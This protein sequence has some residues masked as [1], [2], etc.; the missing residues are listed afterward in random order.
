MNMGPIDMSYHNEGILTFCKTESQFL[1]QSVRFL[2]CDLAGLEGLTNLVSNH[3]MPLWRRSVVCSYWRLNNIN[4]LST[5]MG[6]WPVHLCPSSPDSSHNP[7]CRPDSGK[8]FFPLF[9]CMGIRLVTA[10]GICPFAYLC[11]RKDLRRINSSG[12]LSC[13]LSRKDKFRHF[14]VNSSRQRETT[15]ANMPE[16]WERQ[17]QIWAPHR[18][19]TC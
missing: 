18:S 19:K 12:P 8:W 14:P 9:M 7:F 6:S 11:K 4:F 5:V 15:S 16:K 10:M 1:P 2:R 3:F 13:D 17:I